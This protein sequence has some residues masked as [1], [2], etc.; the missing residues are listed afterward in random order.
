MPSPKPFKVH[1]P[2]SV[3]TDLKDRLSRTRWPDE[4]PNSGWAYGANWAYMKK[5]ADYWLNRFDWR[6]QQQKINSFSNF[7]AV[8][9]GLE[10]HFIHERGKG[11][12][13][14]P[15]IITHG[16]PSSFV[17]MLKL[18]PMLTDPARF[19]GNPAD[20]FDVVVPSMPGYGFSDI[21]REKS[22]LR[23]KITDLWVKLMEGL[24]YKRFSAHG[25]DIGAGITNRL[26]RLYP[27]KLVGIHITSVV[28]PYLG[29][30]APEL[31]KAEK[32][33]VKMRDE[34]EADEGGYS[35]VQGTRPQTLAYGLNDSPVGLAAWIVE[36]FR[37][38][39][40]CGG[41]LEKSFTKD[42][43][44][45]NITIYWATQT[46]NSSI[47]LYYDSRHNPNP[48]PFRLGEKIQTPAAVALTREEVDH[49]PR[50]WVERAYNLKHWTEFPKGGHFIALEQPELLAQDLRAFFRTLR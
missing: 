2:D 23:P 5:L 6:A 45:T 35:H 29:P 31:S 27:E 30:G 32:A 49:A 25:G 37:S 43:L 40:D 26:G 12:N 42:E 17:E 24:G 18:I 21:P 41:D 1:I 4:I 15:L 50:E 46:L 3:L 22:G 39:S 34:W 47:R 28:D 7:K 14:M 38:W 48:M 11:P 19:G 10:I 44:L 20:S 16:W 9:D 33:F 13:P 36:K 8:I